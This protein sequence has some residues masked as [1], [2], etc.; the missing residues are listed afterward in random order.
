M[1]E[2]PQSLGTPEEFHQM[3]VA[4]AVDYAPRRFA[5]CEEYGDR[6]DGRVFAWGLAYGDH[7]VVCPEVSGLLPCSFGSP[8]RALSLFSLSGQ[9]RLVWIDQPPESE[10]EEE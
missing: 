6:I 4:L 10:R 3:L 1:F 8:E 9:M 2:S 5:I 7:A